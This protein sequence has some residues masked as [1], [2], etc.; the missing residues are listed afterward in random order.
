MILIAIGV[1]I[2]IVAWWMTSLLGRIERNEHDLNRIK[3][4][5]GL[6]DKDN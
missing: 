2:T 5:L 1:L 4:V 3:H 6:Q